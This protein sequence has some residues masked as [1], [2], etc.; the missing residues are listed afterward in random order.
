MERM[1]SR[2]LRIGAVGNGFQEIIIELTMGKNEGF[3]FLP[4]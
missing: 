4:K 2:V 1:G 3:D